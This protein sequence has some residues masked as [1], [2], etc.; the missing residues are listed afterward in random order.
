MIQNQYCGL[1]CA[2]V[3]CVRVKTLNIFN[4][5][6]WDVNMHMKMTTDLNK[7]YRNQCNSEWVGGIYALCF[8]IGD[9]HHG[10]IQKN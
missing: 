10:T 8:S 6:F 9:H 1:K 3:R 7:K 2:R 4:I 5:G